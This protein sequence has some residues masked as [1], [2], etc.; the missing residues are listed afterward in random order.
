LL[1]NIVD[2][3]RNII[4]TCRDVE[5]KI[6]AFNIL[7]SKTILL[8]TILRDK[9]FF[10][11]KLIGLLTTNEDNAIKEKLIQTVGLLALREN[12]KSF[13]TTFLNKN[14]MNILFTISNSDDIIHKENLIKLL[15][16]YTKYLKNIYNSKLVEGALEILINMLFSYDSFGII[17][18][19]ILKMEG[20]FPYTTTTA[21]Q[22]FGY[23]LEFVLFEQDKAD[24]L[25]D[26]IKKRNGYF[27]A[28][29]MSSEH[30]ASDD[31]E[32]NRWRVNMNIDIE[33]DEL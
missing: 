28:V 33:I 9:N 5:T 11:C 12:D 6:L 20:V 22:R 2:S 18:I 16:Y 26:I 4:F 17:V 32:S 23:L 19:D 3:I 25:Y 14:I 21:M 15:L 31:T 30:P 29:L 10:F 8:D 1:N 27:N 13:Y 7:H 24:Q